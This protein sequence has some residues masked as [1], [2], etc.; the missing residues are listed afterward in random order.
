MKK[1]K[2]KQD[3]SSNCINFISL[4]NRFRCMICQKIRLRGIF[5]K[6]DDNYNI[7]ICQSASCFAKAKTYK[8]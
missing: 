1:R 8:I 2:T 6:I 7:K 4:I 5:V 3:E